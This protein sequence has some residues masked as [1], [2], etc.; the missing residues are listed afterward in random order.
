M[1]PVFRLCFMQKFANA[2]HCKVELKRQVR[3]W[4]RQGVG[5]RDFVQLH[6]GDGMEI[7]CLDRYG[8]G[9]TEAIAK[10]RDTP[11]DW[12][13]PCSSKIESYAYGA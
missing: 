8:L 6:V 1:V 11:H 12:R 3:H 2:E 4:I 5:R 9:S 10:S 7:D 13:S